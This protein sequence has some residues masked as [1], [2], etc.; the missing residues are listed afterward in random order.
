MILCSR[1]TSSKKHWSSNF[2][3]GKIDVNFPDLVLS[4]LDQ[5]DELALTDQKN[6][7]ML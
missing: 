5:V 3:Y 4:D 2:D 6:Y 7:G 1:G